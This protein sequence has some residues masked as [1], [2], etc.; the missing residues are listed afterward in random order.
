MAFIASLVRSSALWTDL[1]QEPFRQFVPG[2]AE[3]E[4]RM[5]HPFSSSD[6]LAELGREVSAWT[7]VRTAAEAST[8]KGFDKKTRTEIQRWLRDEGARRCQWAQLDMPAYGI[9]DG[10]GR[11]GLMVNGNSGCA[12]D[13]AH[14]IEALEARVK[15]GG[16][17]PFAISLG[18]RD[19]KLAAR[20]WDSPEEVADMKN[21]IRFAYAKSGKPVDLVGHSLGCLRT[22]HAAYDLGQEGDGHM[23]GK[24]ILAAGNIRGFSMAAGQRFNPWVQMLFPTAAA[25][26]PGRGLFKDIAKDGV[27]CEALFS[28]DGELDGLLGSEVNRR[29]LV[30]APENRFVVPKIGHFGTVWNTGPL[31]AAILAGDKLNGADPRTWPE[32]TASR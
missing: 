16:A 10:P 11:I 14:T 6:Q 29:L 19:P 24:V 5:A 3:L 23:I 7:P 17:R 31:I 8:A 26:D 15:T 1:V 25:M 30:P 32:L 27:P 20:Q 22:L 9:P 2:Y 4:R 13:Y 28:I 18:D 21:A 12:D